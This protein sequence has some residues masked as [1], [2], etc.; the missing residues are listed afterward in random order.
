MRPASPRSYSSPEELAAVYER[1][2]DLLFS[3]RRLA[4]RLA[5][6]TDDQAKEAAEAMGFDPDHLTGAQAALVV[7]KVCNLGKAQDECDIRSTGDH[8][9]PRGLG[10]L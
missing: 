9:R 6:V 5:N 7:R 2:S 4:A 3:T 1:L 10:A 8:Q